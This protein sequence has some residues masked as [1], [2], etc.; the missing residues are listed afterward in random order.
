MRYCAVCG[1]HSKSLGTSASGTRA[2][3]E[4][5]LSFHYLPGDCKV[6]KKW[7]VAMDNPCY[8]DS[9][10]GSLKSVVICLKHFQD[11]DFCDAGT[12]NTSSMQ[13]RSRRK[14]NKGTS[15]AL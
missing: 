3:A 7:L 13:S 6:D 9:D 1:C 15:A 10:P 11:M 5:N 12:S 4:S 14:L 2:V 8:K